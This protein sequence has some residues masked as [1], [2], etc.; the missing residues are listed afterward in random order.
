VEAL[1]WLHNESRENACSVVDE[2]MSACGDDERP[3]LLPVPPVYERGDARVVFG[4]RG[5]FSLW[6]AS[7]RLGRGVVESKHATDVEAPPPPPPAAPPPS[8]FTS[9]TS[10]SSS[11]SAVPDTATLRVCMSVHNPGKPC[12][13]IGA[14]ASSQPPSCSACPQTSCW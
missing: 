6:D 4:E 12:S 5:T 7:I 11:S 2:L 13:N 1:K 9:S 10:S 14:R 8:S 3:P